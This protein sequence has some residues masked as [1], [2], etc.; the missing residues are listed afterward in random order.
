[1]KRRLAVAM[2]IMLTIAGCS[3]DDSSRQEAH[4]TD[5]ESVPLAAE[6]TEVSLTPLRV[7]GDPIASADEVAPQPSPELA[8]AVE[9]GEARPGG[10]IT[11]DRFQRWK[12][13][14]GLRVNLEGQIGRRDHLQQLLN[15]AE[16]DEDRF[17]E[18]FGFE[19]V[20]P[21]ESADAKLKMFQLVRWRLQDELRGSEQTIDQLQTRIARHT[22]QGDTPMSKPLADFGLTDNMLAKLAEFGINDAHEFTLHFYLPEQHDSLAKLFSIEPGEAERMVGDIADAVPKSELDE[23]VR[24]A[25]REHGFGVLP[26]DLDEGTE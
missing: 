21:G 7:T 22:F 19:P 23:L 17:V 18:R 6:E 11:D 8:G 2:T 10:P 1:M 24:E 26:P 3:D 5:G 25:R 16:Q 15:L 12:I 9:R 13:T 20:R 14:A 4:L